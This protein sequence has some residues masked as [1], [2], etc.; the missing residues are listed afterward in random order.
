MVAAENSR[1]GAFRIVRKGT[2]AGCVGKAWPWLHRTIGGR[3]WGIQQIPQMI[4]F[5]PG[6]EARS[7]P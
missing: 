5:H 7:K 1:S 4:T 6:P 2:S 3:R